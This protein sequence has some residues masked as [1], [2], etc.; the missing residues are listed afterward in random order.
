MKTTEHNNK[1]MKTEELFK[2]LDLKGIRYTLINDGIAIDMSTVK[3]GDIGWL[4]DTINKT[5]KNVCTGCFSWIKA[6]LK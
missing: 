5:D 3:K 4:V 1:T 2:A 6:K